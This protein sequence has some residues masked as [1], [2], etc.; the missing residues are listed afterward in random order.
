MRGFH[1]SLSTLLL[2]VATVALG[3]GL[4]RAA[5]VHAVHVAFNVTLALLVAASIRA[6]LV[7]PGAGAWCFGFA[8]FGWAHLILDEGDYGRY[9]PTYWLVEHVLRPAAER[10]RPFPPGPYP[11]DDPRQS[12]NFYFN[13][14]ANKT[15]GLVVTLWVAIL[16]GCLTSAVAS[17]RDARRAGRVRSH[18]LVR[19]DTP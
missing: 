12:A 4:I 1:T 14:A 11:P 2:L 7:R 9:M 18:S 8:L 13:V 15:V 3:L 6:Y 16:G 19:D 5:T 17:I 10:W